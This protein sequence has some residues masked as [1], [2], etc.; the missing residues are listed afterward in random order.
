MKTFDKK[1]V[2]LFAGLILAIVAT[3]V[4]WNNNNTMKKDLKGEKIK[5][6]A[7]L[8]EKLMLDKS[9]E[10]M[11][12]ELTSLKGKNVQL[13]KRIAEINK[14]IEA[15]EIELKRLKAENSSLRSFREKVQELETQIAQLNNKLNALK[16]ESEKEKGK[17]LK[18]SQHLNARLA[19]AQKE[20][21]KLVTNN[22]IIRAM[23]SNNHR[24]EAVRGKNDKLTAIARRTQKLILA[25]DLPSDVGNNIYFNIIT[26]EG[27]NFTSLN[28]NLVKVEVTQNNENFFAQT[29]QLGNVP[30]KSIEMIYKPNNQLTNGIYEFEVYNDNSY[31]GS[32]KLRLR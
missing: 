24:V 21:E 10:K 31:I 20:N 19:A 18:E 8:S 6:E 13:N 29:S 4:L 32:T 9:L 27:K 26:P 7:L 16:E 3:G 5:S 28:S 14:Q 15:K 1:Q 23:A 30:T 22:I 12:G 25:F 17:L 11:N 2:V